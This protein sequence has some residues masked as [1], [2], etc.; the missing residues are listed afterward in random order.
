M[1]HFLE[2]ATKIKVRIKIRMNKKLTIIDGSQGEGGGQILR[3][4]LTLSMCTGTPVRIENIRAGRKKTGLLRQH[5]ACVRASKTISNATVVGDELGSSTVEF[6]PQA[7]QAGDYEFS[8]GSAGSTSLVFQTVLPALLMANAQSTVTLS[9]G[10]HND[11]APSFDFIQGCFLPA[12]KTIN[13]DV[14]SE[15]NTYGFMPIGGGK[16]CATIHPVNGV[17]VLNMNSIGE[18]TQKQAIV[19]QSGVSRS[20]AERELARVKKK[21]QWSE[22]ELHIKQVESVG[23]GNI[24][25]LRITDGKL[26]HIVEAVGSKNV[27]ADRVAGRAASAMKQYLNSGAAVGEYLCDQLLLPLALFNGGRFTTTELSLHSQTNI[28][29]IKRFIDCNVDVKKIDGNQFEVTVET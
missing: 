29:V 16:W 12:L 24:V 20:V 13:I 9:G 21:L 1:T 17:G 10:T 6:H 23:P 4:T 26:H 19:T 7:I 3:S 22:S 25:S 28:D 2:N 8:I 14:Q 15:L 18:L 5:L 11:L 27:T